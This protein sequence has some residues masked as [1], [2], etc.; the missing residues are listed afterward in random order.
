VPKGFQQLARNM[1]RGALCSPTRNAESPDLQN[2]KSRD[3][4]RVT[5][6]A[7]VVS[8]DSPLGLLSVIL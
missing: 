7:K 5:P 2:E 3:R 1:R 6:G 4:G 8:H